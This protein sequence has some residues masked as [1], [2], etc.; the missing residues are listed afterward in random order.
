V[1]I[2]QTIEIGSLRSSLPGP[3]AILD[4]NN[5]SCLS[6]RELRAPVKKQSLRDA[7]MAGWKY[8]RFSLLDD[9]DPVYHVEDNR[10]MIEKEKETH[11]HS[12]DICNQLY[13]CIV[14]HVACI[15]HLLQVDRSLRPFCL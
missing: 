12:Q 8:A 6:A 5:A 3:S 1:A 15:L 9:A 10:R 7:T 11:A 2:R 13:S 14:P 4:V